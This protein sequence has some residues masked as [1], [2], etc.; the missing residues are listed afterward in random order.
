MTTCFVDD[1]RT[2]HR[3]LCGRTVDSVIMSDRPATCRS[4]SDRWARLG[5]TFPLPATAT[6]KETP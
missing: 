6:V 4:C 2:D 5:W 1:T 3:T